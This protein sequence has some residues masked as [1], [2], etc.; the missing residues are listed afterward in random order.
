MAYAVH[1]H[2]HTE[3]IARGKNGG[4]HRLLFKSTGIHFQFIDG[5]ILVGFLTAFIGLVLLL[6]K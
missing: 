6:S 2:M 1:H 3:F 4:H 5:V